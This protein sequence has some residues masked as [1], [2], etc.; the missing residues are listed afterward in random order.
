MQFSERV[1]AGS[2][3]IEP[4]GD[5]SEMVHSIEC[6]RTPG[7]VEPAD[8]RDRAVIYRQAP[9]RERLQFQIDVPEDD[10]MYSA[11]P[12]REWKHQIAATLWDAFLNQSSFVMRF[13]SS[14]PA[15]VGLTVVTEVNREFIP[16]A[17]DHPEVLVKLPESLEP[18]WL[19]DW[20]ARA[21]SLNTMR[22]NSRT[23]HVIGTIC[24]W[25]FLLAP[26]PQR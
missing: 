15:I 12:K 16:F 22:L 5:I 8:F 20:D 13:R 18:V 1:P 21:H 10:L 17:E 19:K 9:S 23:N 24:Q 26:A 3:S 4:L 2:L 11:G 6:E 14:E 7:D 25:T